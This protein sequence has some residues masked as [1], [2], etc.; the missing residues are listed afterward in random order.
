MVDKALRRHG[1]IL[2]AR[3][4]VVSKRI[5]GNTATRRE[6]ACYFD[7]F[8]LHQGNEVFHNNID[9]IFVKGAMIAKAEQVEF[10]TFAFYHF[11]RWQVADAN[12]SKIGLP[13]NGAQAGKFGT[14]E[15]HPIVV[16]GMLVDKRL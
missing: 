16:V 7:V 5:D 3:L 2:G 6:N 15:P 4:S 10:Q 1:F 11:H 8:G 12:F 14:V 13:R 9:T